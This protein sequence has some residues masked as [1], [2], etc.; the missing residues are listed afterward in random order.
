[1]AKGYCCL[2]GQT[3]V[4]L[5]IN[6]NVVTG[7]GKLKGSGH[8]QAKGAVIVHLDDKNLPP[9]RTTSFC[10]ISERYFENR[11]KRKILG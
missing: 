11:Y 1:M 2:D 9:V 4:S 10:F 5:S 7:S 8:F 6:Q 3:T